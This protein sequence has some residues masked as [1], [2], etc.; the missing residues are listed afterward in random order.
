MKLEHHK[1]PGSQ[2]TWDRDYFVF[3]EPLKESD[4]T[5]ET[6][7][8]TL[9]MG[10]TYRTP[11]PKRVCFAIRVMLAD[12]IA[13]Q[14]EAYGLLPEAN[15]YF[16][17]ATSVRS[18]SREFYQDWSYRG[19]RTE[20]QRKARR[21]EVLA[22]ARERRVEKLPEAASKLIKDF[23]SRVEYRA[24]R[25]TAAYMEAW[26]SVLTGS[27]LDPDWA[28]EHLNLTGLDALEEQRAALKEQLAQVT[29]QIRE[30]RN[31]AMLAYL[32][33]QKWE[34]SPTGEDGGCARLPKPL[35]EQVAAK[36][37]ANEGFMER[38]GRIM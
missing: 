36:L 31:R 5:I 13:D 10:G 15:E 28:K 30:F 27:T 9:D 23:I 14:L 37:A 12:D 26:L 33:E 21:E 7:E 6:P 24:Q 4:F 3:T 19:C 11:R 16:S 17:H 32:N 38:Y 1:A 25:R 8:P 2:D 35:V 34:I 22:T 18:W 29:T 20:A